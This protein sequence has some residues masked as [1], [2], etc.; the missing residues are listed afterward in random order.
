[1]LGVGAVE[2]AGRLG[3]AFVARA[4]GVLSVRQWRPAIGADAAG[5]WRV[6]FAVE[7]ADAPVFANTAARL[8]AANIAAEDPRFARATGPLHLLGDGTSPAESFAFVRAAVGPARRPVAVRPLVVQ[9]DHWPEHAALPWL[10]DG[11]KRGAGVVLV[12]SE[13]QPIAW[14]EL[15]L[16]RWLVDALLAFPVLAT[17]F[18]PDYRTTPPAKPPVQQQ[19]ESQ[20]N[21]VDLSKNVDPYA[22]EANG[23]A[24]VVYFDYD[25]Y[26]VKAEFGPVLDGH[27]KLMNKDAQ[28]KLVV[29]G[30]TD[31]RGSREYN[32]ALGTRR[33]E[34]VRK[35]LVLRGVADAR[36]EATSAGME[37]PAD[38]GHDEAAWA[39]NRRAELTYRR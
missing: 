1:M 14:D 20:V 32:L 13:D 21:G 16:H 31:E 15:T 2:P 17:E 5:V 19:P 7:P 36:I 39:K 30:H 12:G 25:S 8:C 26:M 27:T 11:L 29:Q 3:T 22:A 23:L 33:A 10:R 4:D 9:L 34:A 28:R 37:A 6:A 24:K 35:E 18:F 38:P